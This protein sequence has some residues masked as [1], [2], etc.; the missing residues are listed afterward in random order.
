[1]I[2]LSLNYYLHDSSA[3][4]VKDG[5]LSTAIEEERLIM[6]K[7]TQ[8]FPELAIKKCLDITGLT[9]L[10]ID[11]IEVSIKPTT[12]WFNKLTFLIKHPKLFMPFFGHHVVNAYA[13]QVKFKIWANKT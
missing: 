3:C 4:I 12:S 7:H 5:I 6:D 1:M 8:S 2:I 9:F 11:H 10:D 13:K